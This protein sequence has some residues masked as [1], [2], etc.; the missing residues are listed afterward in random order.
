MIE[1]DL[2]TYLATLLP[3]VPVDLSATP[4]EKGRVSQSQP[5]P[6]VHF[7]RAE[8]NRDVDL[9]G[10]GMLYETAFDVEVGAVNDDPTCQTIAEALKEGQT[11]AGGLNGY[12]G[13]MGGNFCHGAFVSDHADDY[14][15]KLLDA[16]DGWNIAAFRVL[17]IHQ[18]A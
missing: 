7:Q 3:T 1:E 11:G 14:E 15:P 16:D 12:R 2:R 9:S 18:S 6:R 8:S 10:S 13:A 5:S 4:I 17:V